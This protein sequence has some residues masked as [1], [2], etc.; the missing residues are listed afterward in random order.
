MG[1]PSGL[2]PRGKLLQWFLG[3]WLTIRSAVGR[4]SC[5]V[6]LTEITVAPVAQGSDSPLE[7]HRG[8]FVKA[9]GL[10]KLLVSLL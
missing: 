3:R 10:G 7:S 9:V 6:R 5:K 8:C 2:L 1:D 4:D